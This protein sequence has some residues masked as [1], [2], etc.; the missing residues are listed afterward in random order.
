MAFQEQ[1]YHNKQDLHVPVQKPR[2]RK[3]STLEEDERTSALQ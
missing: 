2:K 3:L 1:A